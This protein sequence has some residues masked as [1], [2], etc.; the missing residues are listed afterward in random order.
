MTPKEKLTAVLAWLD[1][2]ENLIMQNKVMMTVFRVLNGNVTMIRLGFYGIEEA[3]LES[4]TFTTWH[5][6]PVSF[7][8][9]DALMSDRQMDF[10]LDDELV[11]N[12]P[13]QP[14]IF[15]YKFE[16]VG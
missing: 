4:I 10:V 12:H 7:H 6:D 2:R 9:W 8:H 16:V 5:D 15:R 13:P 1:A 3:V 11:S 14:I